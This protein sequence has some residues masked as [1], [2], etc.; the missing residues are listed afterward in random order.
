M[1]SIRDLVERLEIGDKVRWYAETDSTQRIP[2]TVKNAL[3]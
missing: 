2:Y 1:S 3:A